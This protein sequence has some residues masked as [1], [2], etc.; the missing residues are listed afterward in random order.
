MALDSES[1]RLTGIIIIVIWFVIEGIFSFYQNS[2]GVFVDQNIHDL[3][4]DSLL[5]NT[6]IVYHFGFGFFYFVMAWGFWDAKPWIRLPAIVVLSVTTG[7]TWV[8]FSFQLTTAFQ[9]ILETILMGV[10]ITYLMKSNVKKYFGIIS[11]ERKNQINFEFLQTKSRVSP[12]LQTVITMILCVL[13]SISLISWIMIAGDS[14]VLDFNNGF[15]IERLLIYALLPLSI[16]VPFAR[17]GK[18]TKITPGVIG[19]SVVSM[20]FVFV[21]Y[22]VMLILPVIVSSLSV[23]FIGYFMYKWSKQWNQNLKIETN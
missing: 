8:L 19:A 9:S 6:L 18:I 15:F 3:F 11:V 4:A 14:D 5:E 12:I 10:V 17:I 13:S 22:P 23:I 7:I 1:K 2:F 21:I 20:T 16:F